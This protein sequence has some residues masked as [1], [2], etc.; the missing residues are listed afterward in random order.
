M[1]RTK[2][3]PASHKKVFVETFDGRTL[4]GYVTPA[5]MDHAESLELLSPSGEVMQIEW[6][7]VRAVYFVNDFQH[8]FQPERKNFLSRPKLDGL[9]V[10]LKYRDEE[11]LEGVVANDLLALLDRGIHLVPPDPATNCTRMFIPRQALA[12]LTVLGVVGVARRTPARRPAVPQPTL[13][14]E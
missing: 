14:N 9:W 12:T 6:P 11:E 5:H 2:E 13:F 3:S 1:A 7:Q 4:P 8:K 10:R